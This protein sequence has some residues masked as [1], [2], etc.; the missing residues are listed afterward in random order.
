MSNLPD[1]ALAGTDELARQFMVGLRV[2]VFE[3]Q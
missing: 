2:S 1:Y 3:R